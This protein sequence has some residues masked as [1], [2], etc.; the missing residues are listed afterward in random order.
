M[1]D[2]NQPKTPAGRNTLNGQDIRDTLDKALASAYQQAPGEGFETRWRGA[3]RQKAAFKAQKDRPRG[4]ALLWRRAM[5][6]VAAVVLMVG[7]V[8][9][10]PA[11]RSR[12]QEPEP[13]QTR[14][15][16]AYSAYDAAYEEPAGAEAEASMGYSAEAEVPAEPETGW[17]IPTLC[18]AAGVG[19]GAWTVLWGR[20]KRKARPD[21]KDATGQRGG[22]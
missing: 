19:L 21:K 4:S 10:S 5:P 16:A 13:M 12:T 20:K 18:V 9:F 3:V 8:L 15:M 22:N 2:L 1:K 17:L 11:I 6:A 14:R 7:T